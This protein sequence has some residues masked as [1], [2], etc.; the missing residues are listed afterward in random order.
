MALINLQN[1]TVS[2][3]GLP[4]LEQLNFQIEPRE[5]VCLIGRNGAG[6]STLMKLVDGRIEADS[7]KVERNN[8]LVSARLPQQVHASLEGSVYQVVAAGIGEVGCL[9]AEFHEASLVL[10]NSTSAA[11]MQRFEDIQHRLEAADGWSMAS[12]VESVLSRLLLS[13]EADFSALSG[14]MQR[15]VLLAR[16]L[17]QMPTLLLLDEPTNHLDIE[18]IAWLEEFLLQFSGSLLFVSHDRR[19]VDRL[20]TRIV[21]LDRGRLTSWPGEYSVY[22]SRKQAALEAEATQ[23]AEFD[24]KL[25]QEEVWIR[26]GI[27]ARRTRNE[28]RVRKL[29]QLREQRSQR[30]SVEGMARLTINEAERSGKMVIE[31]EQI[32]YSVGQQSI[33]ADFSTTIMRGDRIGIIGPNGCGKTTLLNLLV[34]KLDASEGNIR[35]GTRLEVAYFDQHRAGLL[36]D[37]TVQD[38][39]TG[40]NEQVSIRGESRH[41]ISY[42]GDFLFS[43]Q[44]ARSPVSVL[45][46]GERNRLLLAKL[47]AKPCNLLVMDEPTNDLDMETLDLLEELL[48]EFPGTLLLVSH[49][50]AF[51][52]NVITS[53]L[54]FD[55]GVLHESVGGYSDWLRSREAKSSENTARV[56]QSIKN[57]SNKAIKPASMGYQQKRELEQLPARIEQLEIQQQA[58]YKQLAEPEFYQQPSARMTRVKSELE[59]IEQQLGECYA[60]WETLESHASSG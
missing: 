26:Q 6:K 17:V 44:R 59:T 50:R 13:P 2:F 22:L 34:G 57:S 48:L 19:F 32:T 49:D 37:Q 27:K 47:F 9:L 20:A 54:V 56:K 52:D 12:R 8:S 10:G 33:I 31:A 35:Y 53:A 38:N 28:G 4:V 41:V 51:L 55:N 11:D 14:G 46:G 36:D 25:A 45:S 7:G 42:L 30:R 58:L 60:R 43:P 1:I 23:N 29:E 16:A 15:R 5:R 3:G 21:E 24:K 40:G 39:I 18:S